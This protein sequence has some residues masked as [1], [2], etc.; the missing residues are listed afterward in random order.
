[1]RD[2][3]RVAVVGAGR[4][5][6]A[7]ATALADAG[8]GVEG[9]LRRGELPGPDAGVVLLCVPDR[10]IASA[11]S[12]IPSGPVV[13]HCS[14]VSTLA[15]LGAHRGFS[16]HPLMTVP[17]AGAT[18]FRGVACAVSGDAV[19]EALARRLGM[20]PIT[21]AD[22]NRAAYHAA[23]SMASNFLVA[24]E[25]AAERVGR[26]AGL[27]R[28][29]L[30]PLVR[31]TVENWARLGSDALTG[32]LTRGDEDTIALHRGALAV[33]APELLTLYDTMVEVARR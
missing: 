24:L 2:L 16:L 21:I 23:A 26:T 3:E 30:L 8:L 4:L 33:R 27:T 17:A 10:E 7:L 13:G 5:G 22:E 14:G 19:A 11:A 32:P 31:A 29:D 6:T 25:D 20:R 1:M 12:A 9:P 15:P 28:D 18:D